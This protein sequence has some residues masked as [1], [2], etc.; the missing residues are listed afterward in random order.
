[1]MGRLSKR[2]IRCDDQAGL[3]ASIPR[4]SKTALRRF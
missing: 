2:L 4:N 3:E 1:M